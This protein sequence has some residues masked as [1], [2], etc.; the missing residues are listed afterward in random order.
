ML[1]KILEY[2]KQ[3]DPYTC[4]SAAIAKAIGSTDVMSI[5]R[6]L[7]AK[8]EPGSYVVMGNYLKPRVRSYRFLAD[9]SLNDAKAAL[10]DGAIVITHGWYTA[11]GHVITLVGYEPDPNFLSYRFIVDDPFAE[12]NFKTGLYIS[13]TSGNNVRYSSYG[14]YAYCVASANYGQARSIYRRKELN[15]SMKNAWLHIVKN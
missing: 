10:D 5:R 9:G 2:V 7:L 15:S 13:G 14:I 6:A 1:R 3:P 12:Y 8:G 11:S 4:Q